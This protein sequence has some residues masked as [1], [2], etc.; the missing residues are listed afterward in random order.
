MAGLT[1]QDIGACCCGGGG[2]CTCPSTICVTACG[3]TTAILGATVTVSTLAPVL[4]V[5]GGCVSVC[6]DTLGGAGSYQVT[7]SKTGFI[8]YS[9]TLALTCHGTKFI[10]LLPVAST[11][12]VTFNV[13]GCCSKLLPGATV[14]VGGASYTTDSSGQ[15]KLGITDAGTY[16]W[17]VSK[18]R[19][20]TQTGSFT[21]TACN[22]GGIAAINRTLV[23]ASGFHCAP[24]KTLGTPVSL[25]DPA[26]DVLNGSDSTYGAFTLTYQT[27]ALWGTGWQVTKQVSWSANCGCV[28]GNVTLTYFM[29]SCGSGLSVT[30]PAKS[31]HIH[32]GCNCPCDAAADPTNCGSYLITK[33]GGP[34]SDSLSPT[35]PFNYTAS[36]VMINCPTVGTAGPPIY[37]GGASWTVTE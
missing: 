4:T 21:I 13:T 22:G 28:A 23:P 34:T 27:T 16:A 18:S 29:G 26:P 6:L 25:A 37:P 12:T 14:T 20:V 9:N 5:T 3:G 15:V 17:S 11:S 10:Q 7:V 2:G 8:T 31:D 1:R 36:A 19:F 33:A 24:A 35:V 30:A 32:C